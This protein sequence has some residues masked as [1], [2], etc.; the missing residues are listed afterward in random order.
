MTGRYGIQYFSNF[1]NSNMNPDDIRSI[2]CRLRIDNT[3]LEKRGGDLFGANPLMDS[4]RVV[5]INLPRIRYLSKTKKE[6][7]PICLS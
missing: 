6:F 5:T 4:I 3:Q 1:I 2:C 7:S